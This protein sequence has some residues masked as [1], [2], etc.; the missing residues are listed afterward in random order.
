MRS[1]KLWLFLAAGGVFLIVAIILLITFGKN[2]GQFFFGRS[3]AEDQL[4]EYVTKVLNQ[5]INGAR[6]QAFDT[7]GNGYVSCDYTT[8]S[9]SNRVRSI[10]CSAWGFDGFLNRGCKTRLPERR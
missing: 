7:D 9:D 10:E 1:V 3:F 2:I 6:C 4:R 8:A 5:E